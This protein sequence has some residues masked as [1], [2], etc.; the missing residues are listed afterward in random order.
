M[1]HLLGLDLEDGYLGLR[2]DEDKRSV[3][4]SLLN[5]IQLLSTILESNSGKVKLSLGVY[6]L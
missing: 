2:K 6:V 3:V 5:G 1:G 4:S